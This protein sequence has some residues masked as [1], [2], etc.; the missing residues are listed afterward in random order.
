LKGTLSPKIVEG[1]QKVFVTTARQFANFHFLPR[2]N[3]AAE[4]EMW[5]NIVTKWEDKVNPSLFYP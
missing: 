5:F 4:R 3:L 1:A 2:V